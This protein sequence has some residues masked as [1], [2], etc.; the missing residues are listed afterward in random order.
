ML[1]HNVDALLI[2]KSP[3]IHNPIYQAIS[4]NSQPFV[5][6]HF[7]ITDAAIIERSLLLLK[8]T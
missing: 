4:Q 8:S 5:L 6:L 2:S 1:V 3:L 7:D